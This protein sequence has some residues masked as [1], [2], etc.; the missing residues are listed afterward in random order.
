M[1]DKCLEVRVASFE[2]MDGIGSILMI[3]VLEI[4]NR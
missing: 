1:H 2:G 4:Y 3:T